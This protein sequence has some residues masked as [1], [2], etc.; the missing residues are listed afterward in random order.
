MEPQQN[1][2]STAALHF[3]LAR[4]YEA[5]RDFDDAWHHYTQGN[6]ARR[7]TVKYDPVETQSQ[8]DACIRVFTRDLIR[9]LTSAANSAVT[10]IFI[11]G[12]PRAGS[13]LIEQML[14]S[15]S[16]VDG[17]GELPY[18]M[19]LSTMLGGRKS[20]DSGYPE[21][22]ADMQ[23]ENLQEL[24]NDYLEYSAERRSTG[25][26][27]FTDKMPGNFLHVGFIHLMLPQAVIID[28]RRNPMDSCVGNYRQLFSQGKNQSYDLQELADYYL[29]Y[30][31]V[32]AHWDSVLPRRVLRV[33][34][35]DVVGDTE[36]QLR[37]ILDHCTLPYEGSCL[38]F[39]ASS[40]PVNTASVEQVREPIYTDA[41]GFWKNYDSHLE[42]LKQILRPVL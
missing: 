30:R 35:E 28:A 20:G 15:H 2:D 33:Q 39:H 25:S 32:M 12:M 27:F 22:L 38:N 37:R 8:N 11:V 10:P 1:D 41:V 29:E 16:L 4:A 6:A 9:R 17:C 36:A 24:G 31:R 7:R 21:I 3:A 34:Y 14:A 5:E 18:V 19:M 13:T 26:R 40:R 23:P 42:E